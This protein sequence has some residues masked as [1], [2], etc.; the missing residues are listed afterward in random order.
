[1]LNSPPVTCETKTFREKERKR[2][3]IRDSILNFRAI[4]WVKRNYR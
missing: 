3:R 1:M 2:A 4:D